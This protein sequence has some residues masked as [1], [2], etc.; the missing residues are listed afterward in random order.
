MPASSG[1]VRGADAVVPVAG[2]QAEAGPGDLTACAGPEGS[3]SEVV[4][5]LTLA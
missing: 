1:D 3:L 5:W 4:S 2:E